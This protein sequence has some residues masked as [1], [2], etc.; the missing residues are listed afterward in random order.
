[1]ARYT[2]CYELSPR[3]RDREARVIAGIRAFQAPRP[4]HRGV[5]TLDAFLSAEQLARYLW[6]TAGLTDGSRLRVALVEEAFSIGA[7]ASEPSRGERV[8][9]LARFVLG[10]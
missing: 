6:A 2:V 3:D 1:M 5:W 7:I 10:R 9:E 8:A 4:K